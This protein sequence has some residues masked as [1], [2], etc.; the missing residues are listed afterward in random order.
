MV[1]N[2]QPDCIAGLRR[3][4]Q[5]GP[6]NKMYTGGGTPKSGI[7][8]HCGFS[9]RMP[10][11]EVE[12]WTM[13]NDLGELQAKSHAMRVPEAQCCVPDAFH[14]DCVVCVLLRCVF[15]VL[16]PCATSSHAAALSVRSVGFVTLSCVQDLP[17][18]CHALRVWDA[19]TRSYAAV[20]PYLVGAPKSA[21]ELDQYFAGVI[22]TLKGSPYL[23]ADF[24]DEFG[25]SERHTF[26][27]V[28]L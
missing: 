19:A 3:M 28:L 12:N 8:S 26:D 23:G 4:L 17:R 18:M 13:T 20:D 6:V 24:V 27:P 7:P 14:S 9:L 15:F 25:T 16:L 5:A 21:A 2:E 22:K 1:S 10:P 11:A